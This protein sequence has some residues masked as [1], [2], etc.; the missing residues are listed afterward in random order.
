VRLGDYLGY[1]GLVRNQ[2]H[3]AQPT[4][5]QDIPGPSRPS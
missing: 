4:R 5:W 2:G 1:P 3:I